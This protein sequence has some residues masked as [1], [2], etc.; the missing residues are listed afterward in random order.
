MDRNALLLYLR[1]I[2][3]LE[4][5]KRKIE[6]IYNTEHNKVVN[7]LQSLREENFHS[8]EM[9]VGGVGTWGLLAVLSG[10]LAYFFHWL[11]GKWAS[12]W[13]SKAMA[14]FF[15]FWYFLLFGACIIFII[16]CIVIFVEALMN[17]NEAQKHNERERQIVKDNNKKADEL[18]KIWKKRDAYLKSEYRK[19]NNLLNEYYDLNIIPMPHRKLASMIYIYGYMSTSQSTLENT[20]FHEQIEDGIKRILGRLDQII[21]QQ[22]TLI[23]RQ[24]KA[25]AQ[26]LTI[27]NQNQKMLQSLERSEQSNLTTSQY[28]KLTADYSRVAAF[29]SA[30]TDVEKK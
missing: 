5:T 12:D 9:D 11:A 27:I 3:D 23:Y 4:I 24:H 19:V 30:A 17:S 1:D 28:A 10:G 16:A 18:E 26:N 7:N 20:L 25:E 21:M 2:R 8:E 13:L 15:K 6:I 22:Q 14:L 29:F